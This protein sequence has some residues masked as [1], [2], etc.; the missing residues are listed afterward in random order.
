[1]FCPGLPLEP[2]GRS[3]RDT[4][5]PTNG[6]HVKEKLIFI[7]PE[8]SLTNGW[9]FIYNC[10][11]VT[12]AGSPR[13]FFES[14]KLPFRI[15]NFVS[16]RRLSDEQAI[17]VARKAVAKL[18]HGPEITYTD[19]ESRLIRPKTTLGMPE[20]PRLMIEW[21]YPTNRQLARAVWI[22]A[23]VDCD[24]GTVEALQY[25]VTELWKAGPDLGIPIDGSNLL[26][27]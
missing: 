2:V 12:Y 13:R 19:L 25:D 6:H 11:N 18:G 3:E 21:T 17:E 14:D 5:Y 24:R 20:S 7:Q 15:N 22:V 26:R 23:E 1:M 4:I 8:L 27:N 9:E 16:P 10:G